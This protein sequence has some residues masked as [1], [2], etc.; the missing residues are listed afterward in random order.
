MVSGKNRFIKR[1][2]FAVLLFS[3]TCAITYKEV[4]C[5]SDYTV[6]MNWALDLKHSVL[7]D[8]VN[9]L[10][11]FLV[12]SVVTVGKHF[13]RVP[14]EYACA[15]VSGAV[16]VSLFFLIEKKIASKKC[17]GSEIIALALCFITP[18][19]VPWFNAKLYVGQ[20]SP[21][22]WHNPTN[23]MVKPFA[24]AAFYLTIRLLDEIEQKKVADAR[25]L[26][27]LAICSFFSVIAKPSFYQG[28][29]PALGVYIIWRLISKKSYLKLYLR[30]SIAFLPGM[31][32]LILQ[33][34]VSFYSGSGEGIGIGW[35][36]ARDESMGSPI[37]SLLLVVLFPLLYI[38]LNFRR[39]VRNNTI[40]LA[41]IYTAISWLEA[42][43]IVEY[44]KRFYNGNF[45]WASHVAYLVLWVVTSSEFFLDLQNMDL[46]NIKARRKNAVLLTVWLMHLV[47]G[48]YYAY[49]IYTSPNVQC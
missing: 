44:G 21:I 4:I 43:L 11:H 6:H 45:E 31:L 25:Q 42:A 8:V 12:L 20:G 26:I 36:M 48:I 37:I 47:S 5:G 35:F 30:L 40:Q 7:R 33:F 28:F 18:I 24:I 3:V 19:Y 32:I 14:A 17:V 38:M 46:T 34:L 49:F 13:G 29:I 39:A 41:G 9:P 10:W 27:K 22:T 2:V 23:M 16:N 15:L 1:I